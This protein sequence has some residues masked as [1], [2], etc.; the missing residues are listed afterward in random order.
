MSAGIFANERKNPPAVAAEELPASPAES[1][2][3]PSQSASLKFEGESNL[4]SRID[5]PRVPKLDCSTS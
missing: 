1:S 5:F 4:V 3:A 2:D